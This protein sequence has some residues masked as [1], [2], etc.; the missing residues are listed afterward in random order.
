[1]Q[2]GIWNL[3]AVG[4]TVYVT[5]EPEPEGAGVWFFTRLGGVSSPPF[6]ALNV[7]T[8]VGDS[9]AAVS[10]NLR[11]IGETMGGILASWVRQQ[12]GDEVV[13][14]Y[15]PGLYGEADAMITAER[16]LALTVAVADCV[17][18]V[19]VGEEG[20]GMVHSG[21][22]GTLAGISGKAV[23]EMREPSSNLWAYVGPCIRRCCYEVSGELAA[24]FSERFGAAV[25]NGRQLSLPEAIGADLDE[26]GVG[27]IYDLGLCTGCRGNLFFSHRKHGPATGRNL[28]A[29]SGRQR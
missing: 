8:K 23:R 9:E 6:D 28:A 5:P 16:D 12:A 10:E 26:S 7:S 22:R 18:V 13:R 20:L 21:W 25:V 17:P 14:V 29:V 11:R 19:L 2:T 1:M 15:G 4:D 24:S 27:E 3:G